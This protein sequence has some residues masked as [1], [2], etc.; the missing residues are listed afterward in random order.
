MY[1]KLGDIII[2]YFFKQMHSQ[3]HFFNE[4]CALLLSFSFGGLIIPIYVDLVLY[5][6]I[7]IILSSTENEDIDIHKSAFFT[8][9]PCSTTRFTLTLGEQQDLS[10]TKPVRSFD[11]IVA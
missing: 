10:K 2:L 9:A 8:H 6:C 5:H 1:L 7:G 11:L 3:T 4:R